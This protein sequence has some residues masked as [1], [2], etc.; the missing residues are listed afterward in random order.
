MRATCQYYLIDPWVTSEFFWQVIDIYQSLFD[1]VMTNILTNISTKAPYMKIWY[2]ID[3]TVQWNSVGRPVYW[4]IYCPINQSLYQLI[5]SAKCQWS[6]GEV[7]VYHPLYRPMYMLVTIL[8]KCRSWHWLLVSWVS[9]EYQLSVS[10][11]TTDVLSDVSTD[12]SVNMPIKA[13]H[14]IHDPKY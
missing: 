9:V 10:Q 1:W 5:Y 14:K 2:S 7:S 11:V 13:S 8:T 3:M 12:T 6:I 4:S